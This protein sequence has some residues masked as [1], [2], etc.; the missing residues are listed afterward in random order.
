MNSACHESLVTA[1]T[2]RRRAANLVSGGI[3]STGQVAGPDLGHLGNEVGV[4][5]GEVRTA[6]DRCR[7]WK[8]AAGK[9]RR[10]MAGGGVVVGGGRRGE[11]R[12]FAQGPAD[13]AFPRRC[14]DLLRISF[15][16]LKANA[17][18]GVLSSENPALR[19]RRRL[20]IDIAQINRTTV[21]SRCVR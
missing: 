19:A 11:G 5:S 14:Q 1:L 2:K 18:S 15:K 17:L 4:D 6:S 9:A 7:K 12:I 8:P 20:Q 3:G 21:L 16:R 13:W 10:A